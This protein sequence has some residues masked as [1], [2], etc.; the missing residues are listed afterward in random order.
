[1]T[2]LMDSINQHGDRDII[3]R[4]TTLLQGRAAVHAAYLFGSRVRGS[5]GPASDVDVAFA[6]GAAAWD[7][8]ELQEQLA[9]QLGVPVQVVDLARAGPYIGEAVSREGVRLVGETPLVVEGLLHL[10][11]WAQPL[12]PG[13]TPCQLPRSQPVVLTAR[14]LRCVRQLHSKRLG[15][16][17]SE[18]ARKRSYTLRPFRNGDTSLLA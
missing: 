7:E 12:W 11:L 5:Q 14:L 1:M 10:Q 13:P 3:A 8:V 16:V 18:K 17:G 9:A 6:S 4:L 2:V 15:D